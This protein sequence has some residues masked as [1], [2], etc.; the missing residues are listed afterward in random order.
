MEN[1]VNTESNLYIIAGYLLLNVFHV[2]VLQ[3]EEGDGDNEL[4]EEYL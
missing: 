1:K 2:L 4:Q 3:R